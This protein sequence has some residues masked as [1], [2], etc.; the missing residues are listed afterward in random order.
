MDI[1]K[2]VGIPIGLNIMQQNYPL[3]QSVNTALNQQQGG[4]SI[5][6]TEGKK[7]VLESMSKKSTACSKIRIQNMGPKLLPSYFL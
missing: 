2:N 3:I 4:A 7:S 1:F 6:D 5:L